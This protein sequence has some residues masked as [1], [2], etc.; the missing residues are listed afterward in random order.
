MD[1]VLAERIPI[2]EYSV[3]YGISISTLRRRIKDQRVDYSLEE[4]RYMI[5][6][7]PLE[8]QLPGSIEA[9]GC[10]GKIGQKSVGFTD[11]KERS[12]EIDFATAN[13]LLNE[14]KAAY[15][16]M[17]KTK[18]GQILDLKRQIADLQTL[19][20]VLEGKLKTRT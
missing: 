14:L 5:K 8:R 9:N 13:L 4:G 10:E 12:G 17:L 3:K 2:N 7:L 11:H 1:A 18:D 19:N 6:D 20:Q 15:S 16:A